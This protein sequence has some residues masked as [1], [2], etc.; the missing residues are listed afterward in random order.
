MYYRIIPLYPLVFDAYN[1]GGLLANGTGAEI[2]AQLSEVKVVLTQ[3]EAPG[4]GEGRTQSQILPEPSVASQQGAQ[5]HLWPTVV[6][7]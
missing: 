3:A 7:S 4:H 6:S 1:S 2:K 5:D